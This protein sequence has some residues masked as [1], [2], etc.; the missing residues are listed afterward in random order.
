MT[1]TSII[2]SLIIAGLSLIGAIFS[3]GIVF[4]KAKKTTLMNISQDHHSF[5]KD[6]A[7]QKAF[8]SESFRLAK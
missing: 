1:N 8:K 2:L 3:I 5:Y 7:P 4:L 6:H